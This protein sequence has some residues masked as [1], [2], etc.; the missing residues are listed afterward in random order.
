MTQTPASAPAVDAPV[1]SPCSGPEYRALD[2]L[3]GHWRIVETANGKLF[4]D[5]LIKRANDNCAILE[6]L[7]MVSGT[8][9]LSVNFYLPS[10]ASWH[11][12]YHD[13]GGHFAHMTGAII[14]GRHEVAGDV[15]L[16]HEPNRL[17]SVRQVTE[18]NAAR[19]PHQVGYVRNEKDGSWTVLYDVTFCKSPSKQKDQPPCA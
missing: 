4:A 15:R 13:S 10:D 3:V 2:Y 18:R 12:L 7:T 8:K 17:R 19:H 11:T 6:E 14:D 5:N 1:A 16:P 9:G